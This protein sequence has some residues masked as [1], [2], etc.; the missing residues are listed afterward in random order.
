[1]GWLHLALNVKPAQAGT[2]YS[3]PCLVLLTSG[4]WLPAFAGMTPCGGADAIR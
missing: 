3:T 2:Q 4:Y 1:M